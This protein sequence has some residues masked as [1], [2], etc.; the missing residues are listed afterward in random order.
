[1]LVEYDAVIRDQIKE[2]VV[3]R[4]NNVAVGKEFYLPHR[5]VVRE[6][7]ETTKTR[8][9]C[10]ASARERENTP[11]LNDCFLTGPP[12]QNQL[13]TVLVRNCFHPV[14]VAGDLQKAFLRVREAERDALRFHCIKDLHSFEVEVLRLQESCLG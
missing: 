5:A 12:L 14:A 13:W 10:D 8:I 2:G 6:N 1:M 4:A 3:E 7:A 11:S 9:V